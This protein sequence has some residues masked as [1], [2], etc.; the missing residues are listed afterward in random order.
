MSAA[1]QERSPNTG[2]AANPL[3]PASRGAHSKRR[4]AIPRL[5]WLRL[6]STQP[7]Y[8]QA[9]RKAHQFAAQHPLLYR[10]RLGALIVCAA[11]RQVFAAALLLILPFAFPWA[12]KGS[13]LLAPIYSSPVLRWAFL[14]LVYCTWIPVAL[15]YLAATIRGFFL[16]L[17][18]ARGIELAESEAPRFFRFLAEL[19]RSLDTEP[20]ARVV[21]TPDHLLEARRLPR[22][23]LLGPAETVLLIGLPVLEELSPQ[24]FRAQAA[25]ELAH[26][27]T[28]NRRLGGWVLGLRARLRA[29]RQAAE[30]S[31]VER[32]FWTSQPDEALA[33]ILD[34]LL[35]RLGPESLPA[36]RQHESQADA[37]AAAVAGRE[38]A[39]AALVRR[40][41]AGHTLA[42]QFRGE[43]LRLAEACPVPPEDTFEGRAEAARTAFSQSQVHAWLRYELELKDDL[44]DAHPPLWDRL[45]M[46]G[47]Q[48]ENLDDF[49]A[50]LEATR[51]HDELGETAARFFLGDRAMDCRERFFREW[52]ERQAAG[53]RLRF[54]A[55]EKLRRTA[56]EWPAA[57]NHGDS[58]EL[59]QIAV[60]I[61]NTQS[62]RAAFPVAECIL[63]LDP[64]HGD[65]NL[66]K[67]QLN[68]EDGN[69]AGLDALERAMAADAASIVPACLA[70][71]RFLESRG[72]TE[73][74]ARYKARAEERRQAEKVIAEERKQVR[75]TDT[76]SAAHLPGEAA[77][78][79]L[80]ALEEHASHIHSAYLLEKR[81]PGGGAKPLYVLGIERRTFL[82]QNAVRGNRLLL[83]RI[84]EVPGLP[85]EILVCVITRANR[86]LLAKWKSIPEGFFWSPAMRRATGHA[87]TRAVTQSPRALPLLR[88]PLAPGPVPVR[89][90]PAPVK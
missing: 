84:S 9:C 5:S 76:L 29:L 22:R 60:A 16:P 48:L 80:R 85:G 3:P 1:P 24:Q 58:A 61:G 38:F 79:L 49:Q 27:S 75:A 86:G 45:R 53:W 15:L 44:T 13:T 56:A 88:E 74:A 42:E 72:E 54:D 50:F 20:V 51:P 40:R 18:E 77:N 33:D 67:G 89:Q 26:F 4:T 28:H 35:G 68:L 37:I 39:A 43:C 83:R 8:E 36:A 55:Y 25:H 23:G 73:A 66:L 64:A 69:P 31:A 10:W 71:S 32:G 11:L 81:V 87:P 7:T 41:L 70:A 21:I 30:S 78:A 34:K 12:F 17:A 90:N 62:W 19:C 82:Y 52:A 57:A 59:W 65:A 14:V 63:E 46:F 2:S 6:H 47:Y